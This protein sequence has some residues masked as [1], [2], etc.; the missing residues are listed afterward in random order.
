MRVPQDPRQ[1]Q[2]QPLPPLFPRLGRAARFAYGAVAVLAVLTLWGWI[3]DA[4]RLRDFGADF[5]QM[6]FAAALGFLLLACSFFSAS[7]DN[8]RQRRASY[9]AA[10]AAAL[11]ALLSLVEN[12]AGVNLGMNF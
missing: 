2:A 4:P 11:I 6:P 8:P 3:L 7:A 5:P 10:A 12:V 1:L 9:A